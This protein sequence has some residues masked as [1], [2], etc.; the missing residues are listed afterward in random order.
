MRGS[1][2]ETLKLYKTFKENA[3]CITCGED[4]YATLEF[5]H[6]DPSTKTMAVG[7]MVR[8]GYSWNTIRDEMDKCDVLC[9]NCHRKVHY[10][11]S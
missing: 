7:K 6:R 5:H 1:K 2:K 11:P 9:S 4:H 8:M 3:A 10:R